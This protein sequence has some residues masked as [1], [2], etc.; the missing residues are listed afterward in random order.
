MSLPRSEARVSLKRVAAVTAGLSVF[1]AIAGAFA[2][3]SAA[4]L[5]EAIG[6]RSLE[7]FLFL[8]GAE[9][10]APLG[11]VLMPFAGWALMR[12]VPLGRAFVG[13]I[14]GTLV[15]GIVGWF[16]K[17]HPYGGFPLPNALVGGLIGFLCAVLALRAMSNRAARRK[18]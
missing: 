1:G 11:A 12:R 13:T 9:F 10:G 5:V 4:F 17:P 16:S 3:G 18:L 7:P 8:V 15:G 2:G 14:A 6:N